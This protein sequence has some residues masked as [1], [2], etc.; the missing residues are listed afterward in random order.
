LRKELKFDGVI[1]SDDLEMKAISSRWSSERAAVL[2][3]QAGCDIV[4]VCQEPDA[5]ALAIEGLVRAFES[6]ELSREEA[7]A[8][9]RRI[10][11][12]KARFLGE[13][14]DPDPGTARL[15]AGRA[16]HQELARRIEAEGGYK[17]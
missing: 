10:S 6:G 9:D 8:A 11:R 12:L 14:L 7:D 5:Q 3:A 16:N 1:V 15:M 2:A 13:N 17:A 4:L